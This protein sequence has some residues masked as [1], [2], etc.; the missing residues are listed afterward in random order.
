MMAGSASRSTTHA[1]AQYKVSADS[2]VTA[3]GARAP[4]PLEAGK[5]WFAVVRAELLYVSHEAYVK[6]PTRVCPCVKPLKLPLS[7][8]PLL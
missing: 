2:P 6:Y 4:L 7:V 1:R 8:D 5:D 3:V